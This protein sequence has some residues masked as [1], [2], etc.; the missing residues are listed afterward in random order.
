MVQKNRVAYY[1]E[2][3]QEDAKGRAVDAVRLM[4]KRDAEGVPLNRI[5]RELNEKGYTTLSGERWCIAAIR[6]KLNLC[7]HIEIIKIG[8]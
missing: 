3:R 1:W 2:L 6:Q 8:V 5:A 7:D 4:L